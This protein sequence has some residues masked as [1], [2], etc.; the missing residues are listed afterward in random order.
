VTPRMIVR[1]SSSCIGAGGAI[2]FQD[3]TA[4][5]WVMSDLERYGEMVKEH[6]SRTEVP[7][8]PRSDI[9]KTVSV[10]GKGSFSKVYKV[11]VRRSMPTPSGDSNGNG[12]VIRNKDDKRDNDGR[13]KPLHNA[14]YALKCINP[15]RM[16]TEAAF[17]TA[18]ADL[19]Y[20]I[21]IMCQLDHENIVRLEGVASEDFAT[22]FAS[23]RSS[24]SSAGKS[25]GYYVLLE[26]LRE[27]L[28]CRLQRWRLHKSSPAARQNR[29]IPLHQQH[30]Q[31]PRRLRPQTMTTKE[32]RQAI[33][34]GNRIPSAMRG[35][36]EALRY[37]HRKGIV[38]RDVKPD[39]VGFSP[40]GV[41][42]LFDFG[43]ARRL[44]DCHEG[45][46]AG[47]L[48]YMAPENMT[49]GKGDVTSDVYSFGVLLWEVATLH[50]PYG[51]ILP[52]VKSATEFARKLSTQEGG[53]GW[54]H[55]T[56]DVGCPRTRALIQRCWN[57][58]PESRPDFD[59]ICLEME[60]IGKDLAHLPGDIARG[61]S[62][63]PTPPRVGQRLYS[64]PWMK[65]VSRTFLDTRLIRQRAAL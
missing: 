54:R 42:K 41:V 2:V 11:Q 49:G 27:T 50:K 9:V 35:L 59:S 63:G 39:N 13:S 62:Q 28:A 10:L 16:T 45:E 7:R 48:R 51:E 19:A 38:V 1:R 6:L 44:E 56:H 60:E 65:G 29:Q 22:S 20:E 57:P 26:V 18:T 47:S 55:S 5:A 33:E 12:V 37:L 61:L 34:Y 64:S 53:E 17:A 21:S 30:A 31:M 43:L 24:S 8:I 25:C 32:T 14:C 23:S 15:K 36:A 52:T 3:L 46:I 40:D 4:H 58:H